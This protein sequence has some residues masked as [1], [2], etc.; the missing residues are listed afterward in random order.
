MRLKASKTASRQV[1]IQ[2]A[3]PTDL[4][5][6][7]PRGASAGSEGFERHSEATL[8]GCHS[9]PQRD[10]VEY[11]PQPG[12]SSLYGIRTRVTG[13]RGRRPRPLDEQAG[14]P[15]EVTWLGGVLGDGDHHG[16]EL[17][18]EQPQRRPVTR[19][20]VHRAGAALHA[21]DDDRCTAD[22]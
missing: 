18:V 12:R 16:D 1:R 19:V 10:Q 9:N 11:G 5:P 20:E 17:L 7:R 4:L 15:C 13:V 22:A 6:P 2:Q 8:T 21:G 14:W 3:W